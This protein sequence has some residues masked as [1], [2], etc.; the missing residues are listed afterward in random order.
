MSCVTEIRS[1]SYLSSPFKIGACCLIGAITG[2]IFPI[3]SLSQAAIF[4]I[5]GSAA[6][7]GLNSICQQAQW[8][9]S[10][11]LAVIVAKLA[12]HIF[13]FSVA[14][15]FAVNAFSF[16]L[17]FSSSVLF[18]GAFYAA[19]LMLQTALHIAIL[20]CILLCAA[21]EHGKISCT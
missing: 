12:L 5:A 4:A 11:N 8:N 10:K 20:S 6:E 14:G 15:F 3:I 2:K 21:K 18:L 16:P 17:S 1:I 7:L 9:Q 19:S 13:T